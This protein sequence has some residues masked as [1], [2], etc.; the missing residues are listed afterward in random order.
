[1]LWF[2]WACKYSA[3]NSTLWASPCTFHNVLSTS[4]STAHMGSVARMPAW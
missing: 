3:W 1:M 4:E 2:A